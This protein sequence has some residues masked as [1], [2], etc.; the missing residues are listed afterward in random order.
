MSRRPLDRV[1]ELE[2]QRIAL[3]REV[4]ELDD[5]RHRAIVAALDDGESV[6]AVA[7]TLGVTR[8][9]LSKYLARRETP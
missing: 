9:A 1:H 7:R 3:L 6:A 2:A 8:Q 5:H 4:D